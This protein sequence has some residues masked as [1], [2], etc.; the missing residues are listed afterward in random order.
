VKQRG[1]TLPVFSVELAVGIK[2]DTVNQLQIAELREW[3]L[4]LIR[5]YR[6]NVVQVSYD[7]WN[8]KESI[9]TLRRAGI[10][11]V[12]I[13]LD[14]TPEP[15]EVFRQALYDLRVLLPNNELLRQEL[16]SLEWLAHKNK[17]DH[18]S[19]GS[20]DVAD[21]VAGALY[22]AT[23][24][25]AI[26]SR[27]RIMGEDGK[28]IR[29]PFSMARPKGGVR[30]SSANRPSRNRGSGPDVDM[31][32]EGEFTFDDDEDFDTQEESEQPT[33]AKNGHAL[34]CPLAADT[35]GPRKGG[36][37]PK[38]CTCDYYKLAAHA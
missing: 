6:L 14:R 21:A 37:S 29:S 8:S 19:H 9:Q 25:P 13:S 34:T 7:T 24:Y 17:V 36:G 26:R 10:R 33:T 3:I 16:V 5:T 32:P 27:S 12:N 23:R 38:D 35:V 15:Y 1:E 31:L 20:K 30:P 11:A 4:Q 28:P 2:P 18:P 22:A